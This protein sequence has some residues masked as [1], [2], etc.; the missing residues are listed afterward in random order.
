[1]GIKIIPNCAEDHLHLIYAKFTL[2]FLKE[3]NINLY[4]Q[5]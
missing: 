4:F 2:A 3:M 1:M 5:R